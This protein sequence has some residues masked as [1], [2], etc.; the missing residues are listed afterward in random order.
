[1]EK[2]NFNQR[3]LTDLKSLLI[4]ARASAKT[5]TPNVI[6]MRSHVSSLVLISMSSLK[7][8]LLPVILKREKARI[9]SPPKAKRLEGNFV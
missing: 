2:A 7:N 4:F 5:C 8:S 1:M 9:I 6:R 3:K